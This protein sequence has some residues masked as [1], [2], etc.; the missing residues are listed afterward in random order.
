MTEDVIL[1]PE[2]AKNLRVH[3]GRLFASPSTLR[4]AQGTAS[5]G[6]D[7]VG[8]TPTCST[9]GF[10]QDAAQSD[11]KNK[12]NSAIEWT[13]TCRSLVFVSFDLGLNQTAKMP[14]LLAART[15]FSK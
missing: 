4:Q 6:F 13:V 14:V 3:G 10:A 9:I 7:T 11:I 12:S 5:L 8:R 1:S 2:K 15:S